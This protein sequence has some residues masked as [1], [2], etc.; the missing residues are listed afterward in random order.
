M[1]GV[2]ISIQLNRF[3]GKTS[4]SSNPKNRFV[5][6]NDGG[7]DSGECNPWSGVRQQRGQSRG[8]S[9]V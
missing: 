6:E 8:V 1:P 3:V 5:L 7:F 2:I 4:M 9:V